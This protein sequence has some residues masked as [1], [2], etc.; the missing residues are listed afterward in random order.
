MWQQKHPKV[1]TAYY[2]VISGPACVALTHLIINIYIYLF[3]FYIFFAHI[4]DYSS[5]S[6]KLIWV[7]QFVWYL[8]GW[9]MCYSISLV[10]FFN[11]PLCL[12][13]WSSFFFFFPLDMIFVKV[14]FPCSVITL[15]T[16]TNRGWAG[17][18]RP[19][20]RM[21]FDWSHKDKPEHAHTVR[22]QPWYV[23]SQC[24]VIII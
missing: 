23:T 2:W 20:T 9:L 24:P 22:M 17:F 21:A 13:N 14:R 10:F 4:L 15:I 7:I 1:C 16:C 8:S 12:E 6:L 3:I 11:L 18:V 5:F 19:C